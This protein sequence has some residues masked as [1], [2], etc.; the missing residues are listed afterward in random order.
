MTTAIERR[1]A[2]ANRAE[3]ISLTLRRTDFPVGKP[4]KEDGVI[5]RSGRSGVVAKVWDVCDRFAAKGKSRADILAHCAKLGIAEHTART[6][7]DRW[8]TSERDAA[9]EKAA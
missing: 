4:A 2:K 8:R 5:H 6:Q 1:Y 9:A 3:R 7:F